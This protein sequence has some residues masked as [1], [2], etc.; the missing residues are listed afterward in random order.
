M[1]QF[2]SATSDPRRLWDDGIIPYK[3]SEKFNSK[4][5]AMIKEAIADFKEKTCISFIPH[6]NETQFLVIRTGKGCGAVLG[7]VPG[8]SSQSVSL[9]SGCFSKGILLH[10]LMH[11]LGFI[12]EHNRPDRDEFVK[13]V[14]ANIKDGKKSQFTKRSSDDVQTFN[15]IYDYNS[16]MHYGA[17]VFSK[18]RSEP[19]I[20]PLKKGKKIGQ[21]RGFSD[22]DILKINK[23]YNCEVNGNGVSL[24]Q[25]EDDDD[26]EDMEPLVEHQV[27]NVNLRQNFDFE[28]LGPIVIHELPAPIQGVNGIPSQDYEDLSPMVIHQTK[29]FVNFFKPLLGLWKQ[30]SIPK[31]EFN[32]FFLPSLHKTTVSKA[33]PSILS[34]PEIFK[35]AS[36][37]SN[38]SN[39]FNHGLFS[40]NNLSETLANAK[41]VT[42]PTISVEVIKND[43]KDH[44]I[45]P[46]ENVQEMIV[47]NGTSHIEDDV[48]KSK[49]ISQN[50]FIPIHLPMDI[51]ALHQ[52]VTKHIHP[53]ILTNKIK[54]PEKIFNEESEAFAL[55]NTSTIDVSPMTNAFTVNEENTIHSPLPE[56]SNIFE[57]MFDEI[58]GEGVSDATTEKAISLPTND[59]R[60]D[61]TDHIQVITAAG[62][63][64]STSGGNS[65]IGIDGSMEI[66]NDGRLV[67]P[68]DMTMADRTDDRIPISENDK[69]EITRQPTVSTVINEEIEILTTE[70]L[71]ILNDVS[72]EINNDGA[73]EAIIEEILAIPIVVHMEIPESE[74]IEILTNRNMLP[75]MGEKTIPSEATIA[76]PTEGIIDIPTDS[77]PMLQDGLMEVLVD[78]T[79]LILLDDKM[80]IT[81][82][83]SF[84][85]PNNS[86]AISGRN[87]FP[88]DGA[89]KR[90]ID[91]TL[92]NQLDGDIK[93]P[94]GGSLVIP[95]E[96][97]TAIPDNENKEILINDTAVPSVDVEMLISQDMVTAVTAD[98]SKAVLASGGLQI[99]TD[100]VIPVPE[101]KRVKILADRI[102]LI[103][104]DEKLEITTNRPVTIPNSD[105]IAIPTL[106]TTEI[107][108]SGRMTLPID[109]L[110]EVLIDGRLVI[111]IHDGLE[112]LGSFANRS[113]LLSVDEKMIL[114]N[115]A[116]TAVHTDK[117]MDIPA[118]G[119]LPIRGDE[120]TEIL[121]EKSILTSFDEKIKITTEEFSTAPNVDSVAIS[122]KGSMESSINGRMAFPEDGI[123]PTRGD[124]VAEI[125]SEKS[126]LTSFDEK[127]KIT[128][129]EFSTA[130]N[131]DSVGISTEG[132]MASSINGRM[133]FPK[134]GILPIRGDEVTEILS[135]KSILTSSDKKIKITTDEF[136]TAP[137][138]DSVAISTKGSMESSINGRMAFPKD[139]ILPIRGDEVTEIFSEN[140]I[141]TSLVKK[142]KITTDEFSTAPN[143][144]NVAISTEGSMGSSSNGRKAFPKDGSTRTFTEET[145]LTSMEE[146]KVETTTISTDR[147][148]VTQTQSSIEIST[149]ILTQG[150]STT[151]TDENIIT[152]SDKIIMVPTD[153][154]K[155]ETEKIQTLVFSDE[156]MKFATD[157]TKTLQL[158]KH[159]VIPVDGIEVSVK[160]RTTSMPADGDGVININEATTMATDGIRKN[161][162]AILEDESITNP[163]DRAVK[164]ISDKTS[165]I[166][167]TKIMSAIADVIAENKVT[168]KILKQDNTGTVAEVMPTE[169]ISV[170]A[171]VPNIVSSKQTATQAIMAK[172]TFGPNNLANEVTIQDLNK[173]IE[174]DEISIDKRSTL[175]SIRTNFT[176]NSNEALHISPFSSNEK[177]TEAMLLHDIDIERL[178]EKEVMLPANSHLSQFVREIDI[179]DESVTVK[180]INLDVSHIIGNHA[181]R[182]HRLSIIQAFELRTAVSDPRK[183]WNEGIIPFVLSEKYVIEQKEDILAA[184]K[185]FDERT[186][187]KFI[188]R[189]MENSYLLIEPEDRCVATIGFKIEKS[190]KMPLNEDCYTKGNILHELMLLLGFVHEQN[191]P[192]RDQYVIIVWDNIIPGF[193]QNFWKYSWSEVLSFNLSYDYDSIMHYGAY[194]FAIDVK[195]P[196][197]IALK[198]GIK[199]GQRD[200]FSKKDIIKINKLYHCENLTPQPEVQKTG[201]LSTLIENFKKTFMNLLS[202]FLKKIRQTFRSLRSL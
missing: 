147:T 99:S 27:S 47:K 23:L 198:P 128:T 76:L 185:E 28:D 45:T 120:V 179:N 17:N 156:T 142:I 122:T 103:S 114:L 36:E 134:D 174:R 66:L 164:V 178:E 10:E 48:T 138:I 68:I 42:T 113:E 168:E 166:P 133:A 165:E 67:I 71:K 7:K 70:S 181:K 196:A 126:I 77:T 150:K 148:E 81:T 184:M 153:K 33:S 104:L 14:Y 53:E 4:Q 79:T 30:V 2:R 38:R 86:I 18:N 102:E 5:K 64:V 118:D 143:I 51:M 175:A 141:L 29:S 3:L 95:M 167:K 169:E 194:E 49:I 124:E 92:K 193:R 129:D 98:R 125:S 78:K 90:P 110:R 191:R 16:V 192:D 57:T 182:F 8:G 119:I 83:D 121:S 32:E 131:I 172:V 61:S 35:N 109:E 100:D 177:T 170:D 140:S 107:S 74:T 130:P 112:I 173:L 37:K 80:E 151:L 6:T 101:D 115:D 22:I 62:T 21:R 60:V 146:E 106:E 145:V 161:S 43:P 116:D 40:A 1:I 88:I 190:N 157:A 108:V 73:R 149:G 139:G 65:A 199:L 75:S 84:T 82:K 56:R 9:A 26:D 52:K 171:N 63:I 31:S 15:T 69:T 39:P 137:N 188:P 127:I 19:T 97:P 96:V 91:G 186:C 154:T 144:N 34:T 89:I 94:I 155:A 160:E 197:I 163:K 20:V 183:L 123:L 202:G 24:R 189:K 44:F 59:A 159:T 117:I 158:D 200:G 87:A 25:D 54:K 46:E 195:K 135:E 55:Q 111:P 93:N 132:S 50:P 162:T 41:K 176:T 13:I 105:V 85:I 201:S 72:V 180:D 12:H 136:S 187:V 58:N 152:K 11:A